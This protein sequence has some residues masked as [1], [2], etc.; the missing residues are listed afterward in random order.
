MKKL[1]SLVSAI[2]LYF[3]PLV[4]FVAPAIMITACKTSQTAVA[5]KTISAVQSSVEISLSAWADYVV[6]RN[7]AIAKLPE[8]QRS[9]ESSKLIAREAKARD[10]LDIYKSLATTAIIGLSTGQNLASPE[11]VTSATKFIELTK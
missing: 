9:E 6:A 10:A 1:I 3:S 8:P 11:L 2:T 7:A 4:I 5:Y